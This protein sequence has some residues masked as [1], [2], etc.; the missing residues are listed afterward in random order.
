MG[1]SLSRLLSGASSTWSATAA[2]TAW[3]NAANWTAGVPG[4][5]DG[6]FI[7]TDI[8]TFNNAGN[9][10]T[11]I[12]V[13]ANRNILGITFDTA[14]AAAY[15][16]SGG[17]MLLTSGGVIQLTTT[18]AKTETL[19]NSLVLEGAGGTY[20]FTNNSTSTAGIL[21]FGTG[22]ITGGVAGTTTLTLNGTNTTANT[23][24]GI[25]ADGAATVTLSKSGAGTWLLS[26]RQHV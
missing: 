26:E 7:S 23:I 12:V 4:V 8:A 18:V 25:I 14:A 3:N 6:T 5:N 1:I 15:T 10:K 20:T 9:A 21:V 16:F 2:D 17:P 19:N 11:A 22:G 24:S 13:D